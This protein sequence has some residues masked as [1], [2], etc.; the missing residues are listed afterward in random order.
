[1][2]LSSLLLCTLIGQSL[3]APPV[4]EVLEIPQPGSGRQI[5]QAHFRVPYQLGRRESAAWKTLAALL[6]EGS[7]DFTPSQMVLQTGSAPRFFLGQSSLCIQLEGIKGSLPAQVQ[8]IDSLMRR[9]RLNSDLIRAKAKSLEKGSSDA[10]A[11]SLNSE[12]LEWSQL[13]TDH[14]LE[15]QDQVL[16]PENLTLVVAGDFE[17]GSSAALTAPVFALMPRPARRSSLRFDPPPGFVAPGGNG[18]RAVSLRSRLEAKSVDQAA[19]ALTLSAALTMGKGSSLYRLVREKEGESY[20]VSGFIEPI[21]DSWA[22]RALALQTSG[23]KLSAARMK[24]LLLEDSKAWGE[25][26]LKRAKAMALA[27]LTM[28]THD[29][30]LSIGPERVMPGLETE[31]FLM[32][33]SRGGIRLEALEEAIE[34]VTLKELQAL[35]AEALQ[36]AEGAESKP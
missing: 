28:E 24:S 32:G 14:V 17:P 26:Q 29:A 2:S 33:V 3:S 4:A 25:D 31:A 16:R 23:R 1:M 10:W 9:P 7:L 20:A 27:G 6:K 13:R 19:A 21:Q 12:S 18:I 5:L 22:L 36:R 30:L 35:A 11:R 15:L 8:I 34:Q